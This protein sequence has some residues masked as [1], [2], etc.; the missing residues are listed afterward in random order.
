MFEHIIERGVG[1]AFF[2]GVA[3]LPAETRYRAC[4]GS[5]VPSTPQGDLLVPVILRRREAPGLS[6]SFVIGLEPPGV[7]N[8][9]SAPIKGGTDALKGTDH[10]TLRNN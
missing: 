3:K 2:P 6:L 5:A 10:E 9:L 4:C 8:F 1:L 7:V